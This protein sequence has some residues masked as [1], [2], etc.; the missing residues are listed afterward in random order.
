MYLNR[1]LTNDASSE[2]QHPQQ[3]SEGLRSERLAR[4]KP[5]TPDGE[6]RMGSVSAC[7]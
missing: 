2:T 4:G 6:G 1:I 3:Q 7:V 5:W